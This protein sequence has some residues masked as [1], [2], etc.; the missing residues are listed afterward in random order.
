M[1]LR[2]AAPRAFTCLQS[3]CRRSCDQSILWNSI[4]W[5]S[6]LE[7]HSVPSSWYA[8]DQPSAVKSAAAYSH[9]CECLQNASARRVH[10][11]DLLMNHAP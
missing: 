4:S 8:S 11:A 3:A 10:E 5:T 2:I 1:E 6:S 7:E 9:F